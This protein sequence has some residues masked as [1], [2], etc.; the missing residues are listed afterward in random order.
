MADDGPKPN[1]N[2]DTY[3]VA[4][5]F[6]DH[7]SGSLSDKEQALLVASLKEACDMHRNVLCD[8]ALRRLH[9]LAGDVMSLSEPEVAW[10][11]QA[12]EE[13]AHRRMRCDVQPSADA[14]LSHKEAAD[15]DIWALSVV[16]FLGYA[17]FS[18]HMP[19]PNEIVASFDDLW[20]YLVGVWTHLR[21]SMSNNNNPTEE[22]PW[23]VQR[24]RRMMQAVPAARDALLGDIGQVI[25]NTPTA[26]ANWQEDMKTAWMPRYKDLHDPRKWTTS[27]LWLLEGVIEP[28]AD[29][30]EQAVLA[31]PHADNLGVHPHD[32]ASDATLEKRRAQLPELAALLAPL[33]G[34][35]AGLNSPTGLTYNI[36]AL[37]D[38]R[39]MVSA[40]V[41][42][43]TLATWFLGVTFGLLPA[44]AGQHD[45][46]TDMALE[47]ATGYLVGMDAQSVPP[48]KMQDIRAAW[49]RL[50]Q[51]R[52]EVRAALERMQQAEKA[53][54]DLL[55]KSVK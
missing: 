36:I 48:G 39:G 46:G 38:M 12:L 32:V 7:C 15:L 4:H 50:I 11:T 45:T 53:L 44:A 28:D 5:V 9:L 18:H 24:V 20:P 8:K 42:M 49:T 43:R 19:T 6:L 14:I 47:D 31:H 2:V 35:A 54:Q 21:P 30:L 40:M 41:P 26:W 10:H 22:D 17:S 55:G 25:L 37:G 52:A 34:L 23:I 16:T 1:D 27:D 51:H 33:N 29:L 3:R 13:A